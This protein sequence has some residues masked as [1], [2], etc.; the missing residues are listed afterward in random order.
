MAVEP[1]LPV[2]V[3]VTTD[4]R[5]ARHSFVGHVA[6]PS[7]SRLPATRKNVVP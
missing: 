7:R 3:G 4:R 6:F 1:V 5:D 2:M